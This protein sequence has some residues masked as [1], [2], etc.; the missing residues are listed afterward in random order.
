MPVCIVCGARNA[1]FRFPKRDTEAEKWKTNLCIKKDIHETSRVCSNH[2]DSSDVMRIG[3]KRVLTPG[4]VP[5]KSGV[6]GASNDH[7]YSRNSHDP[8]AENISL[9]IMLLPLLICWLPFLVA[10]FYCSDSGSVSPPSL[11][12]S[13]LIPSIKPVSGTYILSI[14]C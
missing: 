9:W 10:V 14:Y 13:K 2:F 7:N 1:S 5:R 8:I 6:K 11:P 3:G 4:A 12:S